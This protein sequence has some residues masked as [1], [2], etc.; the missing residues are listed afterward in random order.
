[1]TTP[2]NI[3]V[4]LPVGQ[5]IERTKQILFRPFDLARWFI[6][7]FCA[8][9]ATLGEQGFHLP[10]GGGG[11]P[12]HGGAPDMRHQLDQARDYLAHNLFWI[13]P[14]VAV[15]LTLCIGVGLL[16]LWLNS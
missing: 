8:W 15:V 10:G 2:S 1:M 12:G 9:L 5:A 11:S 3:S 16:L 7:G 4:T 6:I 14:L 13:I